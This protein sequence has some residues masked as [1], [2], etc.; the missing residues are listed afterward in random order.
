[1]ITGVEIMVKMENVKQLAL[2]FW[3]MGFSAA[4]EWE[5]RG[6]CQIIKDGRVDMNELRDAVM[7]FQNSGYKGFETFWKAWKAAGGFD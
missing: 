5:G 4:E 3:V 7:R 2:K 6:P 1:M